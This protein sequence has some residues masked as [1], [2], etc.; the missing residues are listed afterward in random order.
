MM[1]NYPGVTRILEAAGLGP[2]FSGIP[3]AVMEA[4]K[5]RG[6]TVHEYVCDHHY[7][8]DPVLPAELAAY[9]DAYLKFLSE[10]GHE[11][12]ISEFEVVSERW[13]FRGFLDR[14]GWLLRRRALIEIKSAQ[15]LDLVPV[16]RQLSAY[17]LAWDEMRP[18]EPL[19]LVVSVQLRADGT[20]RLHEFTKDEMGRAESEFLAAVTVYYAKGRKA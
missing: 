10:S 13:R 17:R 11:P 16:A 8:L 3:K 4:A 19:A 18:A 1:V 7:G 20:Y 15:Q 2:D 12:A 5:I 14:V 9:G 6:R